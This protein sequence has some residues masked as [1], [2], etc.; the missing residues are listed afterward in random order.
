MTNPRLL[1]YAYK[2]P[3]FYE[4]RPNRGT[5]LISNY[6]T[7]MPQPTARVTIGTL[8]SISRP[9]ATQ[10]R[11]AA[12]LFLFFGRL[13]LRRELPGVVSPSRYVAI[14]QKPRLVARLKL[15]RA[16]ARQKQG[17]C[18]NPSSPQ[19]HIAAQ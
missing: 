17:R 14:T 13:C 9:R 2:C 11:I 12:A 6:Q 16:T 15:C 4:N 19:S 7:R 1:V 10:L 5:R 3:E 8:Q 18:K